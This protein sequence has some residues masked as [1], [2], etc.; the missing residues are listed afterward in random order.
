MEVT[1]LARTPGR[2]SGPSLDLRPSASHSAGWKARGR[3][4]AFMYGAGAVL[5]AAALLAPPSGASNRPA[6]LGLCGLAGACAATIPALGRRFTVRVTHVV[7]AAASLMVAGGV[8]LGRGSFLSILYGML[9]VWIAQSTAMFF[10][11]RAAVAHVLFASAAHAAALWTLPPGPRAATW[12][13]TT[14]TCHV[15]LVFYRLMDPSS[16]RLKGIVDH[17]GAA[18]AVVGPDG[19]IDDVAGTTRR[20]FGHEAAGL[21][22]TSVLDLLH[23]D[24]RPA[25]S[26]ALARTVELGEAV[27]FE[28]RLCHATGDWVPV[29]ANLENALDDAA[30]EGVVVT[31]RDVS[32]RKRLE[33]ALAHQAHHDPVTGLPNRTLFADRVRQA[34][35]RRRANVCAVLIVDLDHFKDVNDTLGHAAGDH[36]LEA[37]APL[38]ATVLRGNDTVARLGGD[39]FGVLLRGIS[40]PAEATIVAGR[41]LD[42]LRAPFDVAGTEVHVTASIGIATTQPGSATTVEELLRDADLAM[43]MAKHEGRSRSRLFQPAMHAHLLDRVE[44]ESDLRRAVER[45]E[46]VL[47]YQPLI[48]IGSGGVVGVEALVRWNHPRRGLV[49]PL[50]FIPLAE[51]TGLIVG[52]GQW[53]LGAA[54]AEGRELAAVSSPMD[55]SGSPAAPGALHVSVN[56]SARQLQDPELVG[57]VAEAL[58]RSGLPPERLVLEITETVL[59]DNLE[60]IRTILEELRH[61]GVRIA[62]D[63]FGSGYSSL[64]YLKT[65]PVDILKIDRA[66]VNGL[67]RTAKDGALADAI[68]TLGHS[69]GLATVA[70]GIESE[71]QLDHLHRAGCDLGQGFLFAAPMPLVEL[72]DFLSRPEPVAS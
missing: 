58:S 42:A 8:A 20:L 48:D 49:P 3:S 71:A 47:H 11:P 21:L 10:R 65:L 25:A 31:L 61:L 26:E 59:A 33:H 55:L 29:E 46:L 24:D 43:N 40:D 27:S 41:M 4:A 52:L 6:I 28:A 51:D 7:S 66:F 13:L 44:L 67:G 34:L 64:R 39:E 45:G 57:H 12:L 63:D 69:L 16:A 54:C 72:R 30:L 68:V 56:L 32:E 36:L 60:A 17:S 23:P 35:L 53:I 22:G 37:V 5:A 18:V 2:A 9:F 15:V 19:T 62:I 1:A 38:L 50:Q 14:G 70:E